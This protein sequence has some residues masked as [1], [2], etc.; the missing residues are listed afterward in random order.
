M[1][2]ACEASVVAEAIIETMMQLVSMLLRATSGLSHSYVVDV[3]CQILPGRSIP[4][5]LTGLMHSLEACSRKYTQ[6]VGE[7]E[8]LCIVQ[9]L[10]VIEKAS[11]GRTQ[12]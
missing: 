6:E 3:R 4:E 9:S 11:I 5:A 10:S 1:R 8:W 2:R 12:I 7:L